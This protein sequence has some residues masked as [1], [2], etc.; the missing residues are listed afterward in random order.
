M[1]RIPIAN[2]ITVR[3]YGTWLHGD[4]RG[5]TSR[6]RNRPGQ[7]FHEPNE[8]W[9]KQNQSRLKCPPYVL[10]KR[11]RRIV[12]S[13]VD[14]VCRTKDWKLY[15]KNV[16]TNHFHAVVGSGEVN[17]KKVRSTLKATATKNLRKSGEWVHDYSPWAAKGSV[18]KLYNQ[19]NLRRAI[20]Y[21]LNQQGPD[22]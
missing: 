5:S 20:D 22:I 21:V 2:L 4:K 17:G 1:H 6:F 13:S 7:P 11:A 18:R 8:I 16:R 19:E 12:K 10:S 9:E 15:A 14:E 3:T